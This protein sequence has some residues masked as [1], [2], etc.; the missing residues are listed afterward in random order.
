MSKITKKGKVKIIDDRVIKADN[1]NKKIFDYLKSRNF[2][3]YLEYESRL[4]DESIYPYIEDNSIDNYQKGEDMIKVIAELHNKTSYNKEISHEIYLNIYNNIIGYI[5][6]L[7]DY[8]ALLIE[9]IEYV[10][11]P[12]PS[13]SIFISNYTKL[14]ELFDFIKN[15]TNNWYE[16]VSSSTEERVSLNHGNLRLSHFIRNDKDYLI[17]W[18]KATF[19]TPIL[20]IVKFYHHDMYNVDFKNLIKLYLN[21]C[22]YTEEEKKLLF[23]NLTI[24]K[25]I[26]FTDDEMLNIKIVRELFDYIYKTEDLIR[27]YYSK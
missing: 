12:S 3:N 6:H 27:P 13:Q 4:N 15:E 2:N 7:E 17:S 11:F 9:N 23:I 5:K 8:Y 1:N 14:L 19:D 21:K 26:E 18:D 24:P 16:I 25:K 10:E 22:N 20:D